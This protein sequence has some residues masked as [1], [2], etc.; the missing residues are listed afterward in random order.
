MDG[1]AP[2]EAEIWAVGCKDTN[3]LSV[4]LQ[5]VNFNMVRNET[6]EKGMKKRNYYNILR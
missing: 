1:A 3:Y 5:N 4:K 6:V 2:Y